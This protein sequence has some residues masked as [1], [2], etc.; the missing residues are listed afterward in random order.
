MPIA[1]SPDSARDAADHRVLYIL[2]FGIAG[3][4]VTN[5]LVFIYF[6]LFYASG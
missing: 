5:G 6:V 3:A 4:I 1:I 2:G